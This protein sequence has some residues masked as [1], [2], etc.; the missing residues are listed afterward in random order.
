MEML[1]KFRKGYTAG[2]RKYKKGDYPLIMITNVKKTTADIWFDS[3][4]ETV[5]T[6]LDELFDAV[7]VIK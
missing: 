2:R 6:N 3:A 5:K 7:E 1:V 4:P